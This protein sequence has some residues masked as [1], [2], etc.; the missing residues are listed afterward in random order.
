MSKPAFFPIHYLPDPIEM[1]GM[2]T[3]VMIRE[4]LARDDYKDPGPYKFPQGTVAYL[5]DAPTKEAPRQG[6]SKD[7]AK[8]VKAKEMDGM[9]GMKGMKGM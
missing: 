2:F 6:K 7:A 8:P 9:K 3:V 4:C 1:G 5:V